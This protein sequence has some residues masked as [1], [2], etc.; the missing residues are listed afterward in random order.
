MTVRKDLLRRPVRRGGHTP[1]RIPRTGQVRFRHAQGR[2]DVRGSAGAHVAAR[3]DV[4]C[5]RRDGWPRWKTRS[6]STAWTAS[7]RSS[8][9]LHYTQVVAGASN[10]TTCRQPRREALCGSRHVRHPPRHHRP[11]HLRQGAALRPRRQPRAAGRRD[12]ARRATEPLA[13]RGHRLRHRTPGADLDR[14]RHGTTCACRCARNRWSPL[15]SRL[16]PAR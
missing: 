7:T 8:V 16:R 4:G 6:G 3:T 2:D 9:A 11:P 15:D 14:A 1:T 5:S 10:E 12:R 13:R